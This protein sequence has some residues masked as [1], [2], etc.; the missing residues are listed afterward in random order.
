MYGVFQ[1]SPTIKAALADGS[2]APQKYMS[3]EYEAKDLYL[4]ARAKEFVGA[5][6]LPGLHQRVQPRVPV[7]SQERLPHHHR[8]PSEA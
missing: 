6:G 7:N 5:T 3:S 2:W 4:M 1:F 8:W